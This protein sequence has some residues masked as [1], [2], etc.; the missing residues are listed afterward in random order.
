MPRSRP[1]KRKNLR[2]LSERGYYEELLARDDLTMSAGLD[3]SHD[4]LLYV[5]STADLSRLYD[6]VISDTGRTKK[7]EVPE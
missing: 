6:V 3:P 1:R 7:E 5:G 4:K 2:Q